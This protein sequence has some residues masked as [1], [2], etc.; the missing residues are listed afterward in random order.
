VAV[1]FNRHFKIVILVTAVRIRAANV[2]IHATATQTRS[3]ESPVNRIFRGDLSDALR[4][5]LKDPVAGKQ[6]VKL[7]YGAWKL[8]EKLFAAILETGRQIHHQPTDAEIRRR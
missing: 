8:V 1:S 6:L 2:E 5:P 3:G 4:A 7:V